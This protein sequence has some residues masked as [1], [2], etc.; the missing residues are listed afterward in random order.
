MRGERGITFTSLIIYII[1]LI[2]V[3]GLISSFSGYF[4]S[5]TDEIISKNSAQEEYTRF[6]SYFTKDVNN[7]EEL[8][9]TEVNSTFNC[10]TFTYKTGEKHEFVFEDSKIFY[11]EAKNS[12]V[13]KNIILCTN[14]S[15]KGEAFKIANSRI[16][17]SF[18]IN[19]NKFSN[20]FYIL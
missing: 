20:T 9:N 10:I 16:D 5:N 13:T 6:L 3:I 1:G 14:V 7:K 15:T 12:N 17:I 19:K 2:I 8:S 4:F 18:D 11:K